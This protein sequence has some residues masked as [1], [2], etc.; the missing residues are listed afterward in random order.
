MWLK[1]GTRI[2]LAQPIQ[3]IIS[4]QHYIDIVP[5]QHGLTIEA[6]NVIAT[7]DKSKDHTDFPKFDLSRFETESERSKIIELLKK[8]SDVFMKKREELVGTHAPVHKIKTTD[9]VAVSQNSPIFI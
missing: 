6:Q 3:E 8:V 9:N 4:G 7:I 2:A 5:K 1:P